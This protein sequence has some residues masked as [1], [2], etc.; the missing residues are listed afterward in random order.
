MGSA[1]TREEVWLTAGVP[2]A[3]DPRIL[4]LG[5]IRFESVAEDL[6]V[7]AVLRS[8]LYALASS[9]LTWSQSIVA[10][11]WAEQ[12]A[13]SSRRRALLRRL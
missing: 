11:A 2:A 9:S 10:G 3:A 6:S 7:C 12:Q 4:R 1:A 13:P 5:P 8:V